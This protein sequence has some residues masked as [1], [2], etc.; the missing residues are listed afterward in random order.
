MSLS[1]PM[2]SRETYAPTRDDYGEGVRYLLE[3]LFG[4]DGY[5]GVGI[6]RLCAL[7]DGDEPLSGA[8]VEDGLCHDEVEQRYPGVGAD[9]YGL[10]LLLA[11]RPRPPFLEVWLAHLSWRTSP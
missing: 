4:N 3:P 8:P 2:A 7:P 9:G 5:R 10:I 11:H 1:L 6:H